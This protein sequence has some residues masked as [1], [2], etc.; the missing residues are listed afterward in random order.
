MVHLTTVNRQTNKEFSMP[1]YTY[2]HW[3][4]ATQHRCFCWV[5]VTFLR[6]KK[7]YIYVLHNKQQNRH[8]ITN[9]TAGYFRAFLNIL[10]RPDFRGGKLDGRQ[11]QACFWGGLAIIRH[12]FLKIEWKWA[13]LRNLTREFSFLQWRIYVAK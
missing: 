11:R 10:I 8:A 2:N 3:L 12:I 7:K 13:I 5:Q 1:I 6:K 9:S 4:R